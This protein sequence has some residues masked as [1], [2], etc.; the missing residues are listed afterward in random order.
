M[1]GAQSAPSIGF[2]D[3][4]RVESAPA[5]Q[6]SM[7][8]YSVPSYSSLYADAE[9][10]EPG[11]G[12]YDMPPGFG[13][14]HES[15]KDT[16]PS[17]SLT[18]KHSKAWSKVLI[19]KDH[20]CELMARDTPGPGTYQPEVLNS[21]ANVR[22]GTSKRKPISD[23]AERAPGP[24]YHV[25]TAPTDINHQIKFSKASRFDRDPDAM[26]GSL[27]QTGPGKYQHS[28]QFDGVRLAKS[29]GISHRAYDKVRYPGAE[30]QWVGTLSPGPGSYK[31][32]I[33]DGKRYSFSKAQRL[34]D[35]NTW[36]GKVPG[37][38]QYDNHDKAN[39]SS[40]NQSVYSFGKP[41]AKGR[42]D[43]KQ[44][45]NQTNTTWGITV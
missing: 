37:P 31:P 21:Q 13:V 2:E 6:T 25:R 3:D 42:L 36:K 20:L 27:G 33:L 23:T 7:R 28:T 8:M 39:P 9:D 30:R 18:A 45:R 24:E 16:I 17:M 35:L 38:G 43:W 40:R 19:T 4:R 1:S 10:L 44:L 15:T 26:S 11:P 34:K 12:S 41:H 29:F 32:F 14:Q 22:F 5:S